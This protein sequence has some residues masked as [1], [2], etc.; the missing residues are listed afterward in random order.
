MIDTETSYFLSDTLRDLIQDNRQLLMVISRFGIS[1]RHVNRHVGELAECAGVH[2]DTFLCVANIIS[3]K[4]YD[5]RSVDLRSL[6]EYLKRA[7]TYFLDFFMPEIRLKLLNAIDFSR[8]PDLAVAVMR[9]FDDYVGEVR[10]HMEYENEKLFTYIDGILSGERSE[11]Y[12]V[13]IFA[14]HHDA[15]SYKLKRLKDVLIRYSPEGDVDKLNSAL[16]D[17][18]S[19]EDDLESHCRVEDCIL[20]PAVR[21]AEASVP[22][23]RE[24]T[25]VG[26]DHSHSQD[27]AT[28]VL[29]KR[30]REIIAAVAKGMSNKEIADKLCISVHTVATHR[31]N[32][33]SKLEIHSSAGLT[34]YAI[35]NGIVDL[36][37]IDI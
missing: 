3:G 20:V 10:R 27:E 2:P 32:I 22:V 11:E 13:G 24:R 16:F 12:A 35:L 5:Y 14:E 17:I 33:C 9:F 8:E 28:V 18:I 31:R 6:T 15:V 25:P 19:C 1:L 21:M 7:H 23:R 37:D 36:K 26:Y 34:V 30:E 4:P 29:G